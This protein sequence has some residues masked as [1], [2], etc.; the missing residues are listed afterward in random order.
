MSSIEIVGLSRA[1]TVDHASYT[2]FWI[3]V[4]PSLA[5]LC[6]LMSRSPGEEAAFRDP[7]GR[8][9][10]DNPANRFLTVIHEADFEQLQFDD[11]FLRQLN[12]PATR[13]FDDTSK[14]VISENDSPD[15][16]FRD[17]KSVV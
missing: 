3:R 9:A 15:L 7:I 17:R 5:L 14:S 2:Q 16:P 8:G 12:R 6:N 11:E 1:I 13:Y 10:A 4:F